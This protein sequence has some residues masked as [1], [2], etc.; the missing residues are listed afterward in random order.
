MLT[1]WRDQPKVLCIAVK[2]INVIILTQLVSI[3]AVEESDE[4]VYGVPTENIDTDIF[5][6]SHS[7]Y[8]KYTVS[9]KN[10]NTTVLAYVTPWNKLGYEVT[11]IFG[12]KFNLISP[13]WFEVQGEKKV[14]TVT[15]IHEINTV[16]MNEIR[17][18]NPKL[19][20]TPRF[21]FGPWESK[22][23]ATTLKDNAKMNKCIQNIIN[24]IKKHNFDGAV[25]EIWVQ[26]SGL[27]LKTLTNFIIQLANSLHEAGKLLVLVIPPPVYHGGIE[28]RFR[29]ND[30]NQLANHVDYFSLM[31]YDYSSPRPGPNS[32]LNWVEACIQHLVPETSSN[33]LKLRQQI[34][35]GLNFYGM[36]Y[37]ISKAASNP[38][39]GNEVVE[40]FQNHRPNFTWHKQ[41]AEHSFSYKDNESQD[42]LVFYPTLLSI[43][44]RLQTVISMGTG[45]SIWEIGQGL[46]SFYSLF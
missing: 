4:A 3:V 8:N 34:L 30:F 32:P 1:F 18:V 43:S 12:T 10:L 41:W 19:K 35:V 24:V 9:Q 17:A 6:K 42:H 27:E 26:F 33:Y 20:I 29:Q 16:W 45:V 14:Y 44:Q 7:A 13:V 46:H 40:V 39:R 36:D 22:D 11:K 2:V 28:G 37:I 25:I 38:V 23:Y 31:T 5:L 15:G 21:S